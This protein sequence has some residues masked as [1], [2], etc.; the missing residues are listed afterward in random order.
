MSGFRKTKLLLVLATIIIFMLAVSLGF[1]RNKDDKATSGPGMLTKPMIFDTY[2]STVA[3]LWCRLMNIGFIG[4]DAFNNPSFEW[5]GGSG[6]HYLY[7]G[8]IWVAGKDPAG[9]VH[10]TAGD[11]TE[12]AFTQDQEDV[13]RLWSA[14]DPHFQ[15]RPNLDPSFAGKQVSAE[16]TYAEYND[17]DQQQHAAGQS[18]LGIKVIERTY[19]WTASYN[20]DFF[21]WDFQIINIGLDNDQNGV[22]ET[23]QTL[24]D[25]HVAIRFDADVSYLGGGEYWYDDLTAYYAPAQLSYEFDGDDPDVPGNDTGENG[26]SAGYIYARLLKAA[27]KN[28][29]YTDP[30]SHAWWTID[31]DPTNEELK[32]AYMSTP[33]Y[34]GQPASPYD[35]RFLQTVGPFATFEPGDTINVVW[36]LGVGD[37]LE[38]SI[39]DT[40]WAKRIFDAGF[41]A[42]SAPSAPQLTVE[43]GE[44]AGQAFVKLNWD[45]AAEQSQDPLTG[46]MDFEG[47]RVY[48]SSRVDATGS[49]I[50]IKLADFDVPNTIGANTGLQYQYIDRDV[51]QGVGYSYAITS[52][53]RGDKDAGLDALESSRRDPNASTFMYVSAPAPATVDEVYV[54]PNPYLGSAEWDH[55]FTFNEP[56]RRKLVFANLPAGKC[57]INIF[58]LAGDL[59]D[60]VEKDGDE[61]IALWDLLSKNDQSA[62]SGIYL[63][64]VESPV[65]TKIGKFVIVE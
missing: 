44:T 63:Y 28:E 26:A 33:G 12:F 61:S 8:S 47:Y 31:D 53:D 27:S 60:T 42:A 64:S 30:V 36:A 20:D 24:K 18:P 35:Y 52:Y 34:A 21:I 13:I 4:D 2:N 49:N 7:Q 32:F 5:P 38:G 19:K 54:Y 23:D 45:N 41:L 50:W 9:V 11:E 14:D 6:N 57:V 25:V 51:L 59:V 65:G 10:C 46:Q 16:D 1:A 62:V 17:L 48:K 43:S 55:V 37:G 22:A 3:N 40:D 58:T 39:R 15:N 29:S 56:F